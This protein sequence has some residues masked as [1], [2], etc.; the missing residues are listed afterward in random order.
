MRN[1]I[2]HFLSGEILVSGIVLLILILFVTGIQRSTPDSIHMS[3]LFFFI[4]IFLIFCT[5]L[6][7]EKSA[8]EREYLHKL[9]AGRIAYL[10]GSFVL[11]IGICVQSF[12]HSV[13]PWLVGTLGVMI[14]AKIVSRIRDTIIR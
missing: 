8:D 10:A 12:F 7:R 5:F 9:E 3:L 1:K 4:M 14:L 2:I 6:Y 13:D 11:V